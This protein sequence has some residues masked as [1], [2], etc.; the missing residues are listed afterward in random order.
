MLALDLF[1]GIGGFT[2]GL[3][4]AGFTTVAFCESD[5]RCRRVLRHHWPAVPIHE[6]VRE[7]RADGL[8][9]LDLIAGGFPCQAH[10]TAARGRN[11]APDLWPEFLRIVTD[12]RPDWVAAEN[13]PGIGHDGVDRVC[14]D[15]EG[16]GYVVWPF[17]VD[18]ALPQRQRGRHRFIW[19][20]HANRQSEPRR[21]EHAEV[22][23]LCPIPRRR[24]ADLRAPVGMDDGLPGRMDRLHALGNAITPT[25]AELVGRAI[26]LAVSA[27]SRLSGNNGAANR[28]ADAL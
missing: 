8:G 18:T 19:L 21:T 9:R 10:S 24:E 27:D 6:D 22:A 7:L 3:E 1:S 25:I 13:V 11:N 16:A 20:A 2:L 23:R 4:R 28:E 26:R 17:D 12:A 15:L 14:S 5:E